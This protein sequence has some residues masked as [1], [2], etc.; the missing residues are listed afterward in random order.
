[1]LCR[2]LDEIVNSKHVMNGIRQLGLVFSPQ[3]HPEVKGATIIV[4]TILPEGRTGVHTHPSDQLLLIIEG[5]GIIKRGRR[6]HALSKGTAVYVP[7]GEE[8]DTRNTGTAPLKGLS[9]FIPALPDALVRKL[10]TPKTS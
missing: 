5:E 1:M 6:V 7:A 8:H 9:V 3:I 4:S 2:Q 10:D